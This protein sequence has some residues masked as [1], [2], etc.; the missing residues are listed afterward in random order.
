MTTEYELITSTLDW[1]QNQNYDGQVRDE[2]AEMAKKE[3][4]EK[5]CIPSE[6]FGCGF[7]TRHPKRKS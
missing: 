1:L 6:C 3:Y 7:S 5:N 2:I 4:C